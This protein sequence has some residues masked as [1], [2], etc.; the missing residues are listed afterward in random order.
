[1]VDGATSVVVVDVVLVVVVDVVVV[2]VLDVAGGA[3]VG[4]NNVML[5]WETSVSSPSPPLQEATSNPITST[6]AGSR[7]FMVVIMVHCCR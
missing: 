5:T 4:G 2:E 1:V 6:T 3:E 7:R